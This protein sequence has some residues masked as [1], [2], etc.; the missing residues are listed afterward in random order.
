MNTERI[1]EKSIFDPVA[2]YLK[3]ADTYP[4]LNYEETVALFKIFDQGK[5]AKKLLEKG[6]HLSAEEEENLTARVQDAFEAWQKLINSNLLLVV[7]FARQHLYRGLSFEDLI[8]EGNLGLI[9][10]VEKFDWQRGFQFSSYAGYWIRQKINVAIA[11]KS[12]LISWPIYVYNAWLKINK[13]Q[14]HFYQEQGREPSAEEITEFTGFPKA[15]VIEL[16]QLEKQ[17]GTIS[18]E[19][20]YGDNPDGN[21]IEERLLTLNQKPV[22]ELAASASSKSQITEI[23]LSLPA[24]EAKVIQLCFGLNGNKPMT[25]QEVADIWGLTRER[26]RQL[27]TH[28][29]QRLRHPYR[30]QKLIEP[31]DEAGRVKLRRIDL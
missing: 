3:D 15:R 12:R 22:E 16:L 5:K 25:L 30:R 31:E 9:R 1:G 7:F 11:L 18:L 4:L 13:Y 14:A 27:R 2:T 26:I 20:N 23:L 19:T 29:L 8:Q 6:N 10:A 24:R 28:G 21:P 17:A